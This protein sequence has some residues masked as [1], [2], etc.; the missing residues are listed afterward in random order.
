MRFNSPLEIT[1]CITNRCNLSCTFCLY[2]ARQDQSEEMSPDEMEYVVEEI[3][4]ARVLNLYLT[5]GEPLLIPS[6]PDYVRRFRQARI[7]V[8]V[9]T[10]GT[11]LNG[12]RV[13]HLQ[14]AGVNHVQVSING[15]RPEVNDPLMSSSFDRIVEG[16]EN[17]NRAQIEPRIKVT[18]TRQNIQDMPDLARMLDRFTVELVRF[19]EV[20]PLGRGYRNYGDLKPDLSSLR[21]FREWVDKEGGRLK[22]T[23][24]FSSLTLSMQEVGRASTCTLGDDG[25][26]SCQIMHNGQVIPCAYAQVLSD[27]NNLLEHGLIE[28]WHRMPLFARY[29]DADQLTG[30]CG[31]C[32]MKGECLG[33]CR[34]LAYQQ[35]KGCW[36][37]DPLCPHIPQMEE[38][39]I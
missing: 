25:N 12:E 15:S 29:L 22:N 30:K 6:L 35:G 33:G 2:N 21:S 13:E 14:D 11:L 32:A 36:A 31:R 24:E 38:V 18:V 23:V 4:R 8:T 27:G 17:L 19:H 16:L 9:T 39:V 7:H 28:A 20:G 37:E 1:W 5:G 10:N 26:F 34:A 3:I